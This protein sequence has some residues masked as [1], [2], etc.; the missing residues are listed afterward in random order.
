MNEQII[1]CPIQDV[2]E[3]APDVLEAIFPLIEH[4]QT[5]I[6]VTRQ[7]TFPRGIVMPDGRLDLCKQGLGYLGFQPIAEALA[8][9]RT[10]ASLLLGTNGIG[11][12]GAADVAKLIER[13]QHLEVVYLGCNQI[14][15][16]SELANALTKNTSVTGL[17]LKRNPIGLSGASFI[18]EMLCH[19]HSIRT[20]DLV[21]TNIG[22]QGLAIIIDA[23]IHQNR[24]VERL[25]LGGNQ[26]DCK[27]AQLLATLLRKN[28]TIKAILL[29]V[30]DLGDAGAVALA[31]ALQHNHTLVELGV[32]SNGITPQGGIRLIEAIQKHP[33][34]VNVDLGYSQSTRV[35]GAIANSL[36]DAGA[37]A[38]ANLLVN[39]QTLRKIN[40]RRNG[41]TEQ[42]KLSLIAG[43]QHNRTIRQLILDGKQHSQITALIQRNFHLEP[44][45][46]LAIARDVALIKSVYRG[47]IQ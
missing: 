45:K 47:Q 7:T 4:L 28:S 37:E 24:T 27:G 43:L 10:I 30:N 46:D 15:D 1:H 3:T 42:G 8:A 16:I 34:L 2:M 12:A 35:L 25:Y 36:G 38:I 19:N 29:N 22:D 31:E 23:L 39:N 11:N 32:A 14:A 41:I 13:N 44:E 5:N 26:I 33:A 21:N 9:N 17:W 6:P 18:A 20:L 40:L